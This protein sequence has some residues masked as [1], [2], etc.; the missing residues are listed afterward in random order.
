MADPREI[1]PELALVDT[2]LAGE[3]R[4][5]LPGLVPPRGIAQSPG[6]VPITAPVAD[7]AGVVTPARRAR[8]LRRRRSR[9][10]TLAGAVAAT[11][12]IVGGQLLLGWPLLHGGPDLGGTG[13]TADVPLHLARD[14]QP[15]APAPPS[16]AA[17]A[18]SASSRTLQAPARPAALRPTA[19]RFAW[20]VDPRASYYHFVLSRG[21][22]PIFEAWPKAERLVVRAAWRY[23][24]RRFELRP[25]RYLW[26]VEPGLGKRVEHRVGKSIVRASFVVR[27][28]A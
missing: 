20:V 25:G 26:W 8:P 24:G 16:A 14:L 21:S 2:E 10:S 4:R 7:A 28:K 5:L 1:S 17:D 3:L 11:V 9:R 6:A 23:R 18:A 22:G 15:A 12:L 13:Q 19:H 27:E